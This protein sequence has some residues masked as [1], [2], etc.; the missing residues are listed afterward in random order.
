MS[1]ASPRHCLGRRTR[2]AVTPP[3]RRS[4]WRSLYS[5]I[6]RSRS[7]ERCTPTYGVRTRR[8]SCWKSFS[9]DC[10]LVADLGLSAR[11]HVVTPCRGQPPPRVWRPAVRRPRRRCPCTNGA[12]RAPPRRT[13]TRRG[14]RTSGRGD[15]I[16]GHARLVG[17]LQAVEIAPTPDVAA[18]GDR[19]PVREQEPAADG[20]QAW[21]DVDP[22]GRRHRAMVGRAGT[23]RRPR[24]ARSAGHPGCDGR[25][26]SPP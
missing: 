7:C 6:S 17:Q 11:D 18:D 16:G 14:R 4:S 12:R 15:P 2:S 9:R 19:Q 24:R 5:A 10:G 3:S 20:S 21:R 22:I 26:L 8:P 1:S 25:T 13:T 23:D